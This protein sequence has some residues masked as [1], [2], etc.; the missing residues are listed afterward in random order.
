[1]SEAYADQALLFVGKGLMDAA[2]ELARVDLEQAVA[3]VPAD[4]RVALRKQAQRV[5][6]VGVREGRDLAVV[7]DVTGPRTR[8]GVTMVETRQVQAS[9]RML[10]TVLREQANQGGG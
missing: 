4:L 1:M 10:L 7:F 8:G 3:C 6:D 9:A 5:R 2:T